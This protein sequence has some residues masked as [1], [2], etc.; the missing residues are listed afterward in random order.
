MFPRLA[1]KPHQVR[2]VFAERCRPALYIVGL[3][4]IVSELDDDKIAGIQRGD[5]LT[6][7]G[8]VVIKGVEDLMTALMTLEP[9]K[10]LTATVLREGKSVV[11][12]VTLQPA[13]PRAEK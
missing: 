1:D 6:Q 5:I 2:A 7:L 11:V 4:V 13:Q 12:A 8:P 10:E 3:L 9:H